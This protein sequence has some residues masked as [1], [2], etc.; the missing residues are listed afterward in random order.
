[1][2]RS[3]SLPPL[4][5]FNPFWS[6]RVRDERLLEKLRPAD[7]PRVPNDEWDFELPPVQDGRARGKG[8][9][10]NLG[11]EKARK[12]SRSG[13]GNML[14]RGRVETRLDTT[15]DDFETP[16]SGWMFGKQRQHLGGEGRD[17]NGLSSGE[18]E[19]PVNSGLERELEKS[20]CRLLHEENLKLRLEL[21]M[22]KEAAR[23]ESSWSEVPSRASH[24]W[25]PPPPPMDECPQTPKAKIDKEDRRTPMGTKVPPEPV[26]HWLPPVPPMPV[27]SV[28][29]RDYEWLDERRF[30]HQVEV[31]SFRG[32]KSLEERK[33]SEEQETEVE[34]L[35]ALL[36]NQAFGGWSEYWSMASGHKHQGS[37]GI[38]HDDRAWQHGDGLCHDDRAWQHGDGL[39]HDHRALQHGDG[40]C[41]D[42]RAWQHGD[43]LY[44]DHRALQH[45]GRVCHDD[46][47]LQPQPGCRQ[48]DR[49]LQLQQDLCHRDRA[50]HHQLGNLRGDRAHQHGVVSHHGVQELRQQ[51]DCGVG[52]APRVRIRRRKQDQVKLIRKKRRDW[53]RR[54]LD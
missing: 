30:R 53:K 15:V 24:G 38:C 33:K 26:E 21:E 50:E 42:H 8:S 37:V 29:L 6:Q 46:R 5:T 40:L 25:T 52:S 20:V 32:H 41:H 47:A 11:E 12:R 31:G 34:A 49:A 2:D 13:D 44:P 28:D 16:P 1:M 36:K 19:D 17:S 22:M 39:C 9:G 7:L 43:G 10:G 3:C 4:D 54:L 48:E 18:R 45:R 14:R 51:L 27:T 23:T 35:Q